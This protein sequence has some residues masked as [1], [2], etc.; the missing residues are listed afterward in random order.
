MNISLILLTHNRTKAVFHTLT[1]NL[2]NAGYPIYE[3]IHVDNATED[4]NFCNSFQKTFKPTYQIRNCHNLGVARGYNRGYLNATGSHVLIT[5]MDRLMPE[6][7]LKTI[8]EH[9]KAIPNTGVISVYGP[10]VREGDCYAFSRF[11]DLPDME[12]N[13]LRI[14]LARPFEA[15]ICS[16]DF[17]HRVGFLREDF[18]MYGYEDNEWAMRA[19]REAGKSGLLNY[20]IPSLYAEHYKQDADFIMAN[21]ITHRAWKDSFIE[22][23]KRK[24]EEIETEGFP[25]YNPYF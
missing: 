8:V 25:Y 2:G 3:L 9:F 13:G 17:F 10:P 4:E 5:G 15:R 21:G 18:E 20:I 19:M 6:G 16:R 23:N 7:W 11:F 12:V 1:H 22:K 24:F 14:Q